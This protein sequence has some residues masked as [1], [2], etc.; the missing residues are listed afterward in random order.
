[1]VLHGLQALRELLA[2]ALQLLPQRREPLVKIRPH[3]QW[4]SL[5]P[6]SCE[7]FRSFRQF[8]PG[9]PPR[10]SAGQPLARRRPEHLPHQVPRLLG[11]GRGGAGGGGEQA[12]EPIFVLP[13]RDLPTQQ[14]AE[15]QSSRTIH[16]WALVGEHEDKRHPRSP[17]VRPG[18]V[19]SRPTGQVVHL[20]GHES[21]G[22]SLL[23][24][25]PALRRR[26]RGQAEVPQLQEQPA[27]RLRLDEIVARLDV[28]VDQAPGMDVYKPVQHLPHEVG[29]QHLTA[30][31][32]SLQEGH[33]IP[34]RAQIQNQPDPVITLESID[35]PDEVGMA[36]HLHRPDLTVAEFDATAELLQLL[37][38]HGR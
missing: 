14:L 5:L 18:I 7:L 19:P 24:Q 15:K 8:Q 1:M 12:Q 16:E 36:T 35:Q 30:A 33:E 28:A 26:A 34:P 22:P 37:P 21:R 17:H 10:C 25:K 20:G 31:P 3:Q 2:D 38:V 4:F 23:H 9:V 27:T 6:L 32:A 11:G 29:C 13:Q